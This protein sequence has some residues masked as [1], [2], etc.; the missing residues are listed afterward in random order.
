MVMMNIIINQESWCFAS[1]SHWTCSGSAP[2]LALSL[3]W[4]LR[5]PGE[6]DDFDD[7]CDCDDDAYH[8]EYDGDDDD[9]DG[10]DNGKW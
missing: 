1:W 8:D 4:G 2:C 7:D 5:C 3:G 9:C 10:N 6:H